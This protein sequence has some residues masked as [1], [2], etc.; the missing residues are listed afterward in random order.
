MNYEHAAVD[1]CLQ[2]YSISITIST[3]FFQCKLKT[4]S[5]KTKW[6]QNE[7]LT[8]ILVG[9]CQ[10]TFAI[11]I[12][13]YGI[14][15]CRNLPL[16]SPISSQD[17]FLPA[18]ETT[19]PIGYP[20]I[21]IG[22]IWVDKADPCQQARTLRTHMWRKKGERLHQ[23]CSTKDLPPFSMAETWLNVFGMKGT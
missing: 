11:Y 16:L 21:L 12:M 23:E 8:K 3:F 10:F 4:I 1:N 9:N 22:A 7:D 2:Q 18:Q 15:H 6:Q 13:K 20:F 19:G 5:R 17:H 14:E